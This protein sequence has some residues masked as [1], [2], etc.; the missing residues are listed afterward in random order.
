MIKFNRLE[1]KNLRAVV[2]IRG[3]KASRCCSRRRRGVRGHDAFLDDVGAGS[4]PRDWAPFDE[5]DARRQK[6]RARKPA[7]DQRKDRCGVQ[8][9]REHYGWRIRRQSYSAIS[10][11]SGCKCEEAEPEL[12]CAWAKAAQTQIE[13]VSGYTLACATTHRARRAGGHIPPSIGKRSRAN[14]FQRSAP[15]GVA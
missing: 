13:S 5:A 3:T 2:D 14:I 12:G 4:Q 15:G 9:R 1:W 10:A 8:G 7:N 6:S 11:S